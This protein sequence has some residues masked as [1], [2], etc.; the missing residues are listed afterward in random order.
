M[1]QRRGL[2][3][4]LPASLAE[5]EFG[6][7]L[8]TRELFI[9]NSPGYGGNTNILTQYGP[10]DRLITTKVGVNGAQLQAASVRAIGDKLSDFVSIKDFGAK[11]DGITDDAPAINAAI[12]EL[13]GTVTP[14]TPHDYS[15][16]VTLK[17]PAGVYKI[18]SSIY[19]YPFVSLVGDGIDKTIILA[20]ESSNITALVKTADGGGNTEANIGIDGEPLPEKI[21]VSGLTLGTNG[22]KINVALLDRYQSIRFQDVKFLGGWSISEGTSNQHSGVILRSI[23]T[24]IATYDAQFVG[25]EF[26]NFTYGIYADDPVLYTTI[27]RTVFKN[28]YRGINFG[29]TAI[30]GGPEW[31]VVSATR[32]NSI[33]SHAIASWGTNPGITSTSNYFLDCGSSGTTSPIYW[34]TVSSLNGS[35]GDVFDSNNL[36]GVVD[37]GTDNLINDAQQSNVIGTAGPA[38]PTGPTGEAS[39]IT[40][41]SGSIGPIGPTGPTGSTGDT[42]PTG[43]SVFDGSSIIIITNTSVST[44]TTS[45]ALQIAG[46]VGIEGNLYVGGNLVTSSS[47]IPEIVSSTNIVLTA[48]NKVIISS[49]AFRLASFTTSDRNLLTS[50]N[51]DLIYN[52]TVNRFQGYQNGIWINIDDGS[53]A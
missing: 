8:D 48:A 34:D 52:T 53:L 23:G 17:F 25:C 33:L 4:D 27:D 41:P 36:P 30:A 29:E 10:N 32:F 47:G 45:G 9:G 19:L 7:C 11:G 28:L 44:S 3:E 12:A 6:W 14:P 22:L 40:G 39:T 16:R 15:S 51:G 2:K 37:V 5:G 35:I 31:T 46:G 13:F 20:D 18:S 38:G 26:S 42:G 43:T 21:V 49:S 1:Q 50:E 24:S